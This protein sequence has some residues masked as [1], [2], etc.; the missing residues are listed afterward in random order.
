MLFSNIHTVISQYFIVFTCV[1]TASV[2][3]LKAPFVTLLPLNRYV[4][5]K[6]S[7]KKAVLDRQDRKKEM[8]TQQ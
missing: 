3:E 7:A 6:T 2:T 5:I 1:I 4:A 8:V